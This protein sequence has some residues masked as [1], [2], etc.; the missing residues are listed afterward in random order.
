MR[1]R[2]LH[3]A[4]LAAVLLPAT[5]AGAADSYRHCT[6]ATGKQSPQVRG[7][8]S[9]GLSC[10]ST[11]KVISSIRSSDDWRTAYFSDNATGDA[12]YLTG[13]YDADNYLNE[14]TFTCSYRL[15]G[16]TGKYVLASCRDEHN[17]HV[18][19]HAEFHGR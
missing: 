11:R 1:S 9:H 4:L 19:L 12:S 16:L 3:G 18:T 10:K 6:Y 13:G 2:L 5:S 15:V 17:G 14:R 7:V 8:Y